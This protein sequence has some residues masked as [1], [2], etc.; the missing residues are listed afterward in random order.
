MDRLAILIFTEYHVLLLLY[1]KMIIR[2][3][4]VTTNLFELLYILNF[5]FELTTI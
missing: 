3:I 2:K 5:K 4:H 1:S